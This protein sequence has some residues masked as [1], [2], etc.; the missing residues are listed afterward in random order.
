MTKEGGTILKFVRF[1]L[2]NRLLM[3]LRYIPTTSIK[4]GFDAVLSNLASHISVLSVISNVY[5]APRLSQLDPLIRYFTEVFRNSH[6]TP[7]KMLHVYM[8]N[9]IIEYISKLRL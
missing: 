7:F 9:L 5:L 1:V 8:R 6:Q 3:P 4:V 2:G